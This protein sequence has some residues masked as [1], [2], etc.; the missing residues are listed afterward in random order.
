[1][2]PVF[3]RPR[4]PLAATL[5]LL[6]CDPGEPE[7]AVAAPRPSPAAAA[8]R[9][10]PDRSEL[11][12]QLARSR[13]E[14][15]RR[16]TRALE[17][18]RLDEANRAILEIP[19]EAE[20]DRRLL[21]ARLR[22]REGDAVGAIQSIET[23]RT[24]WPDQGR[25]Y[26]TAAEIHAV[27][28][29][30]ES[31]EEEIRLGL[32]AAGPTPE[33]TRAR[34]ILSLGRETGARVALNHL[35]DARAQDPQLPFCDLPLAQAHVLLGRR[36]MASERPLE[37]LGHAHAA[38]AALE[39]DRD[40][41]DLLAEAR[42]ALGDF[43]GAI[44]TLERLAT[45]GMDVEIR[46]GVACQRGATAALVRG[47]RRLAL[48]RALR[49]RELGLTDEELGFGA[50][51]IEQEGRAALDGGVEAY[52]AERWDEAR[53]AFE[54]AVR[55]LPDSIEARNHFA[56]ALFRAG[57]AA[58]AAEHWAYVVEGAAAEGFELPEPVHLNLAQAL[59]LAGRAEEGRGVLEE[60]LEARPEGRWSE[61]TRAALESRR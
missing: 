15:V 13:H 6:A 27:A 8:G 2:V 42:E 41:L 9:G 53:A 7:R 19:S 18:G 5:L 47:E 4:L 46:L 10:A 22:A 21:R 35:L 48:E 28:G 36:A 33:L 55:C 24:E 56:V 43:G 50:T 26:A 31:A 37:A 17:G 34:G 54:L 30:L 39:G 52:L 45:M 32:G 61:V 40:A 11:P 12:P 49:A 51:L 44:E 29:R 16:A 1:M 58:G 14:A 23:A 59:E 25:I 57:D 60:Y 38:Q 20:L 3:P